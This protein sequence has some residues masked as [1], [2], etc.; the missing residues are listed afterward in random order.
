MSHSEFSIEKLKGASNY[1]NWSFAMAN[2]LDAKGLGNAILSSKADVTKPTET[3]T[4]K[5]S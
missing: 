5:L 4:E 1:H 3:D 2:F